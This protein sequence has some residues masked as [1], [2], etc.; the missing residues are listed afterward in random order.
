VFWLKGSWRKNK[1][2][3]INFSNFSF[4]IYLFFIFYS[5]PWFGLTDEQ[6]EWC[7]IRE[8]IYRFHPKKTVVLPENKIRRFL[9]LLIQHVYFKVFSLSYTL[10]NGFI[11]MISYHR[12][13]ELYFDALSNFF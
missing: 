8:S 3:V 4:S 1:K 10:L 2:H 7:M 11:L 9:S 13:S 5:A 12:Q 6:K